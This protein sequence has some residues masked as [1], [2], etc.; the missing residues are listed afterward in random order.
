MGSL[1]SDGKRMRLKQQR[2]PLYNFG[3]VPLKRDPIVESLIESR[4]FSILENT[5]TRLAQVTS[6]APRLSQRANPFEISPTIADIDNQT[7]DRILSSHSGIKLPSSI[8]S[9]IDNEGLDDGSTGENERG[10]FKNREKILNYFFFVFC[11]K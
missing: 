7:K 4:K 5:Y 11:L 1:R 6:Q 10:R 8:N 9:D 3:I 2:P